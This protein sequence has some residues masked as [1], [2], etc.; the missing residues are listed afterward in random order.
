MLRL[1]WPPGWSP[2]VALLS[3]AAADVWWKRSR[4]CIRAVGGCGAGAYSY[5]VAS[6]CGGCFHCRAGIFDFVIKVNILLIR[7]SSK[8]GSKKDSLKIS[9]LSICRAGHCPITCFEVSSSS[10]H[11]GHV[12][13]VDSKS[14]GSLHRNICLFNPL[15]PV[16]RPITL[17]H[18]FLVSPIISK[19]LVVSTSGKK[20]LDCLQVSCCIHLNDQ[21]LLTC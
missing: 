14:S 18:C 17:A 21:N 19:L 13:G 3:W 16:N 1:L 20:S 5:V 12:G 9:L 7:R 15:C 4:G 10:S 2:N 11:L 8:G 6:A